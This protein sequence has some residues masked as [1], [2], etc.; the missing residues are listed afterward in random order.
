MRILVTGANGL[1]GSAACAAVARAGHDAIALVRPGS[2]RTL[3]EGIAATIREA[4][5]PEPGAVRA[6]LAGIRPDAI[7]HAAA[8]P[9][10]GRPD[11][12]LAL[13]VTVEGTR[14]LLAESVRAGVPRLVL[15]SS[16]SAHPANRAVYGG[17]KW[18]QERLVRE[19]SATAVIAK[20]SLV[21][22][23]QPRGVFHRMVALLRRL[24]VVPLVGD[25]LAPQRPVHV[26]DLAEA[27]ATLATREGLGGRTYMLGGAEEL[28][29]RD[30]LARIATL[31]GRRPLMVPVPLPVCRVIALAGEL[32]LP[33]P[34][35]T[36]DQIEGIARA[37]PCDISAARADFGFAPRS[38][39]D[40][41]RDALAGL[42]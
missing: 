22:G 31:L 19:G 15:V 39:G 32:A 1:V 24:P 25:G 20:P 30:F 41:L 18:M 6:A 28:P 13:R 5:F 2:D 34:P 38:L 17:T 29:F 23:P 42:R 3:L 27:L 26:D 11:L 33:S 12:A 8:V 37:V 16:M 9:S 21:Y 36:F 10:G 40:G 7:I 14:T 4:A 35:L